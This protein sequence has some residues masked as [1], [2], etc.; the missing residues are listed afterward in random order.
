MRN[1]IMIA[2]AAIALTLGITAP[3]AHAAV[4]VTP[5][6][7]APYDVMTIHWCSFGSY[8][9]YLDAYWNIST[10]GTKAK[11][12]QIDVTTDRPTG[13]YY[14]NLSYGDSNGIRTTM[15]KGANSVLPSFLSRNL[16][17]YFAMRETLQGAG[18]PAGNA[19]T[20]VNGLDISLLIPKSLKPHFTES[21]D[22]TGNGDGTTF[23]CSV[24]AP[25]GI[26]T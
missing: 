5:V 20:P 8:T 22:A 4:G 1:K 15:D 26:E 18:D 12:V 7:G 14:H 17:D 6:W 16:V 19:W 25:S 24:Y 10:T 21:Y 23:T 2:F 11:P 9:V 13:L 3:A